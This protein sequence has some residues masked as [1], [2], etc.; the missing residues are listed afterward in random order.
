VDT[1]RWPTLLIVNNVGTN[2]DIPTPFVEEHNQVID[3][4]VN[5]NIGTT[6][7]MTKM[8]L[9]LMLKRSVALNNSA[10]TIL[11][12]MSF[13]STGL[14][15]NVG[16]FAGLIPTAYLSVYSGSKS[17]LSFWSQALG[18]ELQNSGIVV[19]NVCTYFV[20]STRLCFLVHVAVNSN[21]DMQPG[22]QHVQDKTAFCVHPH[23]K[24]LCQEGPGQSWGAWRILLC[25]HVHSVLYPRIN[26]LGYRSSW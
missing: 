22:V 21:C 26:E 6:L 8:V 19:E 3:N 20:V 15:L 7:K 23:P 14:V 18:Q 5:V 16:S 4:I 17:F 1:K 13:S 2:H 24:R 12:D 25:A 11:I 9:P 10:C